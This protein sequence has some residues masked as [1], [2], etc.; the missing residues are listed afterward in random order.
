MA[1]PDAPANTFPVS[2]LPWESFDGFQLN[3][4]KGYAI[5]CPFSP[6]ANTPGMGRR[7]RCPCP[8]RSI[9][10]PVTAS[11]S[12]GFLPLLKEMIAD[13][14]FLRSGRETESSPLPGGGPL[15]NTGEM[16]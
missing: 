13:P 9:T 4:Q 7:Y 6:W 8:F 12:A 5:F 1:K 16:L 11:T 2:M 14:V 3:L 10:R 15:K